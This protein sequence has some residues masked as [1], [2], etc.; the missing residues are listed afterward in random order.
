VAV[1]CN[2][3]SA[4]A[5]QLAHGVADEFLADELK[6]NAPDPV[7][8]PQ[9]RGPRAALERDESY[10]PAA[11]DLAPFAGTYRSEEAE[12]AFVVAI[13]DDGLVVKSR[14]DRTIRLRPRARDTFD[15]AGGVG[16]IVFRRD[17]GRVTGLSVVQDRVWDLRFHREVIRS[18]S[19]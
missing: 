14:P 4:N 18:V 11:T 8:L 1:L 3:G 6:P 19:F 13:E 10:K 9:V 5:A 15:A 16:T 7:P 17:G 2:A 12:A